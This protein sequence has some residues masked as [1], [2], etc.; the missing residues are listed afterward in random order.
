[1]VRSGLFLVVAVGVVVGITACSEVATSPLATPAVAVRSISSLADQ[2][3]SGTAR[4]SS[5]NDAEAPSSSGLCEFSLAIKGLAPNTVYGL[6]IGQEYYPGFA[7]SF[8]TDG[9]GSYRVSGTWPL[10]YLSLNTVWVTLPNG[11]LSYLVMD[12][13]GR[14]DSC[15]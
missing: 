2:S 14:P 11:D 7:N 12:S 13:H 4:L 15:N 3:G 8:T 1:M 10:Y 9:H 6:I 5:W